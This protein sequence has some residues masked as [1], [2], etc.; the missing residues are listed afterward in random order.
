MKRTHY[1]VPHYAVFPV[2]LSPLFGVLLP[3]QVPPKRPHLV[4][5]STVS[6]QHRLA[7]AVKGR[8]NNV[9]IDNTSSSFD[10]TSSTFDNTS[11]SFDN[12]SSSFDNTSSTFDNT[13]SSFDNTSSSFDNTSS[14]FDNTSSS[15][16][17][18]EQ[19]RYLGKPLTL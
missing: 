9:K 14:S 15:F 11:S 10:N 13:S 4:P 17:R 18:A 12:T 1:D 8:N 16:E 6:Y 3:V 5:D 19:F 2:L 7:F